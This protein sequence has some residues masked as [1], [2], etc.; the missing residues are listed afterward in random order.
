MKLVFN[1]LIVLATLANL[2][3]QPSFLLDICDYKTQNFCLEAKGK[4][5]NDFPYIIRCHEEGVWGMKKATQTL[6]NGNICFTLKDMISGKQK[7]IK[8][9]QNFEKITAFDFTDNKLFIAL[10]QKYFLYKLTDFDSSSNIL[11]TEE[12]DDYSAESYIAYNSRLK[13]IADTVWFWSHNH[14]GND[15]KNNIS[16]VIL[17]YITPDGE[18][19]E[20]KGFPLH[21]GWFLD[22]F[23]PCQPFEV[24]KDFFI[25]SDR[26]KYRILFFDRNF[27]LVDSIN[28]EWF[29]KNFYSEDDMQEIE[30]DCEKSFKTESGK[31]FDYIRKKCIFA[32]V[33]TIS[34][35]NAINNETIMVTRSEPL[36]GKLF[37]DFLTC[38]DI[39]VKSNSKWILKHTG[40][41]NY[42]PAKEKYISK[43][44]IPTYNSFDIGFNYIFKS[45]NSPFILEE[46][47]SYEEYKKK[48]DDYYI[49]NNNPYGYFIFKFK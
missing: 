24:T 38:Y 48:E 13:I 42:L 14:T 49:D 25:L 17:H 22:S 29:V 8:V 4:K 12:I 47:M 28:S 33:N 35:I 45:N 5:G 3:A 20:I 30:S 2:N 7:L 26:T 43:S 31:F 40:L 18:K 36:G 19:Y 41:K 15:L 16:S 10:G 46:E 34:N 9:D 1:L 37:F 27:K 6:P 32:N 11:N 21:K 39:W 23:D 44:K